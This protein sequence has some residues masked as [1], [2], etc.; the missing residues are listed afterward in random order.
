MNWFKPKPKLL[1]SSL[2]DF[3]IEQYKWFRT[4]EALDAVVGSTPLD[5][6]QHDKAIYI[7]ERAGSP[8]RVRTAKHNAKNLL[9]FVKNQI[10][11]RYFMYLCT[12]KG[13]PVNTEQFI[14]LRRKE[15]ALLGKH[16]KALEVTDSLNTELMRHGLTPSELTPEGRV[17]IERIK[18]FEILKTA[19]INLSNDRDAFFTSLS[20]LMAPTA[21][22]EIE[23]TVYQR[24]TETESLLKKNGYPVRTAFEYHI[25]LRALKKQVDAQKSNAN[26]Q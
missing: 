18:D 10:D 8:G 4:F 5:A 12:I 7:H 24:M 22:N 14:R 3:P 16:Q 6:L 25:N 1:H 23:D 9:H 21:C 2:K 13:Q 26:S 19:A 15:K 11:Y 20:S 17:S